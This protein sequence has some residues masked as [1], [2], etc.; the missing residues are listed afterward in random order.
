MNIFK[1]K[2]RQAVKI[3]EESSFL[4]KGLAFGSDFD[5]MDFMNNNIFV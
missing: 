4:K 2:K 5:S 1:K 3:F